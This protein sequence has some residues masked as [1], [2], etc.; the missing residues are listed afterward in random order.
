MDKKEPSSNSSGIAQ[1][2]GVLI[3]LF[4]ALMLF[5]GIEG[6]FFVVEHDFIQHPADVNRA[7]D[8]F[9]AVMFLAIGIF[10]GFVSIR[11]IRG[12]HRQ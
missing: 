5:Y 6:A 12:P 1:V 2:L 10:C 8:C 7:S 11:W 9:G 4:A 3:G